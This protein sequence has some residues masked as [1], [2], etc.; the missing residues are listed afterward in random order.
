MA[1]TEYYVSS[2][3]SA[4]WGSATSPSTPASWATMLSSISAGQRANVKADGTYSRTTTVDYFTNSGTIASPIIVR[5]YKTTIGDADQGRPEAGAAL[6][7]TNMPSIT[8]TT[9]YLDLTDAPNSFI[10]LEGLNITASGGTRTVVG[11]TTCVMRNCV[12]E[13]SYNNSSSCP[14][15][16]SANIYVVN[17][18]ITQSGASGYA[19][20]YFGGYGTA[21]DCRIKS[22]GHAC[23]RVT[24]GGVTLFGCILYDS[25]YGIYM[26]NGLSVNLNVINCT[27]QGLS[28]YGYYSYNGSGT[29]IIPVFANCMVTDIST[30]GFANPYKATTHQAIICNHTRT[31]DAGSPPFDG[32]DNWS[33]GCNW[34]AITT[35]TG[36]DTTDYYNHPTDWRLT[37][38][39]PGLRA[40]RPGYYDCGA[41]QDYMYFPEDHEVITT[42]A[43]GANDES[44][45]AYYEP[46]NHHVEY[47][48]NYGPHNNYYG[49]DRLPT[50]AQVAVGVAFGPDDSLTGI[51]YGVGL[52][53]DRAFN[54]GYQR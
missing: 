54:R 6:T 41:V 46:V 25:V 45:G 2:S 17:C 49:T 5:G 42:G 18:D 13:N 20:I 23:V 34:N 53:G 51:Y 32:F 50:T 40:G 28:S 47:L 12:I 44:T 22:V 48:H 15:Y 1:L 30:Y 24:T 10:V 8:Y 14:L 21:V 11:S 43:Y 19:G 35:D 16:S 37:G 33:A 26:T 29:S 36:G 3:G 27:F 7:T 52:G 31:R 4:A 39:S 38:L 9:G